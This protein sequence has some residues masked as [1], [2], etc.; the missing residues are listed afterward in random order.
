LTPELPSLAS[1]SES[2]VSELTNSQEDSIWIIR[3]IIEQKRLASER[4][5]ARSSRALA[6]VAAVLAEEIRNLLGSMELFAGL[7]A[8]ATSQMPETRSGS[9]ICKLD[10]E[11]FPPPCINEASFTEVV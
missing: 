3:D 1:S 11:R 8:D 9:L 2:N 7:L 5:S 4:E 10:F 6:E